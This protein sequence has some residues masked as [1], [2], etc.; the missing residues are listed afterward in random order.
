MLL[1]LLLLLWLWLLLLLLFVTF[2]SWLLD[3]LH[4]C[5]PSHSLDP[6]SPWG[7]SP[8]NL[9]KCHDNKGNVPVASTKRKLDTATYGCFLKWCYRTTMGFPTKNDRFGV[10]WGY[11]HLRKHPYID[12]K[13]G[14]IIIT[15]WTI[16]IFY[17]RYIHLIMFKFNL[18][19]VM[20]D[21]RWCTFPTKIGKKTNKSTK[22]AVGKVTFRTCHVFGSFLFPSLPLYYGSNGFS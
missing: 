15:G 1:L 8:Y 21:F 19:I 11:H 5:S 22:L 16:T 7:C 3:R 12:G 10:F 18:F 17:R 6:A 14:K 20:L 9:E 2:P 13:P 4:S